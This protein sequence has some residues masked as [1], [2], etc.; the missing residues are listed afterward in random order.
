MKKHST[1]TRDEANTARVVAAV[2]SNTP[3]ATGS[4]RRRTQ[5]PSPQTTTR[6]RASRVRPQEQLGTEDIDPAEG[7][8]PA[9]VPGNN[10]WFRLTGRRKPRFVRS[11]NTKT[12]TQNNQPS[13]QTNNKTSMQKATRDID[14][15][16][17]DV[18]TETNQTSEQEND[19]QSDDEAAPSTREQRRTSMQTNEA[20]EQE[21]NETT[22]AE[23][24][25]GQGGSERKANPSIGKNGER[26][27]KTVDTERSKKRN[28]R[29]EA[30]CD[31]EHPS[32]LDRVGEL[33]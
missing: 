8:Q 26:G 16:R 28:S 3:A 30:E 25:Q 17:P 7:K 20:S 11:M 2:G 27:N 1:H 21:S 23:R 33:E 31:A 18:R 19:K 32:H 29:S 22:D 14:T 24:K 9:L 10:R 13:E 4:S 15:D 5:K 6:T 12:R